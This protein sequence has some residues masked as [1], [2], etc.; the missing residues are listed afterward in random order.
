MY[1]F[2]QRRTEIAWT[3]VGYYTGKA[4]EANNIYYIHEFHVT[5]A[6]MAYKLVPNLLMVHCP[7]KPLDGICR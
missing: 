7:F 6:N 2:F 3:K 1:F 4:F 5:E